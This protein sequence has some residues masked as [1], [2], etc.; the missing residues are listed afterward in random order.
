MFS[1]KLRDFAPEILLGFFA[2]FLL[3]GAVGYFSY[4]EIGKLIESESSVSH[5]QEVRVALD[6]LTVCL[7]ETETGQRGYILTGDKSFLT[8]YYT[9]SRRSTDVI[10]RL[11]K[12]LSGD[13]VQKAELDELSPL[14]GKRLAQLKNRIE[15]MQTQGITPPADP[16][17]LAQSRD[18]M[19]QI[20][21][22]CFGMD[23]QE[24]RL[25]IKREA[26]AELAAERTKMIVRLGTAVSL[27]VIALTFL[28]LKRESAARRRNREALRSSEEWLRMITDNMPALIGYIDAEQRYRFNN[29]TYEAWYGVTSGELLGKTVR[30]FMGESGY[31]VVREHLDRCL[32]GK[33]VTFEREMSELKEGRYAQ[34]T[35]LP[36]F[37]ESLRVIGAFILVIDITDRKKAEVEILHAGEAAE[38]ASRAKSEFLANM[39]HEIRT[40]MN[41]ILGM[42]EL[43]NRSSLTEQQKRFVGM[44]KTSADTL[45]GLID[46]ILDVSKIEAGKFELD[47][48][49]FS[50]RDSVATTMS[51][52][53]THAH[54]KNLELAFHIPPHI[55]DGLV[56]DSGRLNQVITNLVGNAVKFT[57]NGEVVLRVS[58]GKQT[59]DDVELRFSVSDT[60]IGIPQ[61]KQKLVFEAFTQADNSTTRRFGGTGLGLTICKEI[62]AMMGGAIRL[63]SLPGKGSTFIFTARIGLAKEP[64]PSH[65]MLPPIDLAGR[66]VLVVDDN[67]TN[68]VILNELLTSW[69]MNPSVAADAAAALQAMERAREA[70]KPYSIVLLDA[71]MP[72][73]DGFHLAERIKESLVETGTTV[74]MLSSAQLTDDVALCRKIG[75]NYLVKPVAP[76][77]LMDSLMI[78][79]SGLEIKSSE[80]E[81]ADTVS[82]SGRSLQI[83][84]AEDNPVNQ[85]VA[86]GFLQDM[87]H[88]IRV[89]PNGKIA[90]ELYEKEDFDLILMD[91]QMPEM[92]GIEATTVI[93]EL[94]KKNGRHIPIAAMTANAMKGDCE[95]CLAAGMDDYVSKPVGA[96][97]VLRLFIRLNLTGGESVAGM[98][99]PAGSPEPKRKKNVRA[100]V[101]EN[102]KDGED[103]LRSIAG[104]FVKHSPRTMAEIGNAISEHDAVRLHAAAHTLKGSV[105]NFVRNGACDIAAQLEQKGRSGDLAGVE[106]LFDE[107]RG[108]MDALCNVLAEF[109]SGA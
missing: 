35:Y 18:L 67:E 28:K 98:E 89:A 83:L 107:L 105:G 63:E 62:V 95:K 38:A 33:R 61:E 13:P 74:T 26:D 57:E 37:D 20:R 78:A 109:E 91:M 27:A 10:K 73:M 76:S 19:D 71:D 22:I 100:A 1:K 93:R 44:I 104:L 84:L 99:S 79:L 32:R 96:K 102:F 42:T 4:H 60:G 36:H 81:K 6:D 52:L 53:S 87:G 70:G 51:I 77:T 47:N 108:E 16:A 43:M 106:P 3:L 9:G 25:L 68:R 72:G 55:P 54:V 30:E 12:L 75:V 39:S 14:V 15:I 46:G 80:K 94:E 29:R 59:D 92:D 41:G 88:S 58:V 5:T 17:Y 56:G 2:T 82:R 66:S 23:M 64:V 48:Q 103:L 85:A 8:P 11:N 45:L 97:D 90:V 101:L 24:A 34:V 7:D 86:I 31:G 49:P 65:S 21:K 40:P 50:L 69:K